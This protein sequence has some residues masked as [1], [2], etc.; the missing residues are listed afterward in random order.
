MSVTFPVNTKIFSMSDF[1]RITVNFFNLK[2]KKGYSI[3][4]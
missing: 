1:T 2:E 3:L 4:K